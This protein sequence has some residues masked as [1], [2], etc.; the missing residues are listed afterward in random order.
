MEGFAG[1]CLEIRGFKARH[2]VDLTPYLDA[3][4][5]NNGRYY[6]G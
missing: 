4:A 5:G 6:L 1:R 3:L 2:G